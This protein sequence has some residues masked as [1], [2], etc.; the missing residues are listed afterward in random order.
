MKNEKQVYREGLLWFPNCQRPTP[1]SLSGRLSSFVAKQPIKLLHPPD[2]LAGVEKPPVRL[3]ALQ[4][5]F[6]CQTLRPPPTS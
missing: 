2:K 3:L 5:F 4:D 6:T 1:A